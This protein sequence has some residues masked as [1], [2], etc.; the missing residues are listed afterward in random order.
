MRCRNAEMLKWY[1]FSR[2]KNKRKREETLSQKS[3]K[4][5]KSSDA[6]LKRNLQ[7]ARDIHCDFY[8]FLKEEAKKEI[9]K[10]V[11]RAIK[12]AKKGKNKVDEHWTMQWNIKYKYNVYIL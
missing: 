6:K 10:S 9:Y 5:V 4:N 11:F 12:I 2:A 3:I 7:P 1:A 8:S